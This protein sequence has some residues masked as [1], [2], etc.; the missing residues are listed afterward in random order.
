M[1][2]RATASPAPGTCGRWPW[3]AEP[4]ARPGGQRATGTSPRRL[5]TG[6]ELSVSGCGP[7]IRWVP[8]CTGKT[9][10]AWPR[11]GPQ[12]MSGN[13]VAVFISNVWIRS[14]GF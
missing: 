7:M 9:G 2:G 11:D 4:Q 14:G 3:R 13:P 10:W 8:F 1:T 6:N 12:V 5:G